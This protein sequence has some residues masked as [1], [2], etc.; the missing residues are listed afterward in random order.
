MYY[1]TGLFEALSLWGPPVQI[2]P[3]VQ[4]TSSPLDHQGTQLKY[5]CYVL[6]GTPGRKER[7]HQ[8]ELDR[9]GR[10]ETGLDR[11]GRVETGLDRGG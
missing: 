11:G 9:G 3:V 8:T 10:M 1:T 4:D 6:T 7:S 2:V 5:G